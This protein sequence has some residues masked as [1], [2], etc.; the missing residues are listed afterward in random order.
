MKTK[1]IFITFLLLLSFFNSQKGY[2]QDYELNHYHRSSLYSILLKHPEQQFSKQIVETFLKIPLPEKY[3]NHNL[4]MAAINA[5]I[6]QSMSKEEIEGAYKDAVSNMLH[7][8]KIGGRLV[9]KW[10]N[11]DKTT[12]AF[13]MNL[14]K[15]RGFY[16]A[17]I[18]DIQ[19]ALHS[20]RGIAQLEDAGEKLLSHTYVLV[21][22]IRY[23]DATLKRNLQGFGVLLG[24]MGSAFVPIVGNALARTIGE[25][26]VAINDLV[27]GFKVYVTSYLYRLDWNNEIAND[28]YSNLWFDSANIDTEKKRQFNSKMGN[29]NLTYIGCTTV[30]SGE[31]SLAGVRCESDMFLKVCTR[32]IDKSISELQKSFDEFKVYSPLISTSPLYAYIG[33][34]EGVDEDSKYEVLEKTVNDNG[35]IEYKRVG[36]IKPMPGK[37]WDNRFMA[38][39]DKTENSD[40]EY[41]TFE[42][43]SGGDFHSGM[44]IREIR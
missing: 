28:F 43:V 38:I 40:L 11:R 33:I 3:N 8:N 12:G 37:I 4:K 13:D 35:R 15:E 32:S 18:L 31:T 9:E 44:L 34:K 10:F 42:K 7:R 36:I 14:V 21:N 30:Y 27:V 24:M 26:G 5:P 29:F 23:A 1:I 41:T 20:T 16:D 17:S 19:E 22:D 2:C 25:T 6:L 39:D